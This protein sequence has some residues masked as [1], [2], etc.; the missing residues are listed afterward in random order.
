M[1]L[2]H[3]LIPL[4]CLIR[5]LHLSRCPRLPAKAGLDLA[6]HQGP[7]GAA[8]SKIVLHGHVDLQVPRGVGTV[9][10]VTL[11]ILVEDVD[12]GRG[13]LMVNRQE[14]EPWEGG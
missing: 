6:E 4:A 2:V 12:G 14:Q 3:N 9:V 8:K 1:V 13:D 11:G 10:Q 5:L 7:V